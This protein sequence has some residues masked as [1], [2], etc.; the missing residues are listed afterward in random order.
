VFR[1]VLFSGV[2]VHSRAEVNWSVLLPSV[3]IGRGAK[4]T[5]TIIDRGCKI[6]EN[7]VIGQDAELDAKRF[8]RSESGVTLVTAEML[9]K[10]TQ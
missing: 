10:L 3:E 6:P 4:I 1:T 9:A 5:K 8:Y 7:M 2:R